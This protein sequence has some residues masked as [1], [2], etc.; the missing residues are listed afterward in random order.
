[1][2]LALTALLGGCMM[3]GVGWGGASSEC[4]N[5]GASAGSQ[6]SMPSCPGGTYQCGYGC[7]SLSALCCTSQ[8]DESTWD[9]GTSECPSMKLSSCNDNP[10]GSCKGTVSGTV[11]PMAASDFCCS[12][13]SDVG[14]LDCTDGTVVCNLMCV[15]VGA[16]CCSL[17]DSSDCGKVGGVMQSGGGGGGTCDGPTSTDGGDGETGTDAGDIETGTCD[18][19]SPTNACGACSCTGDGTCNANSSTCGGSVC[20]WAGPGSVVGNAPFCG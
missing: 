10:S 18:G 16:T 19:N 4:G 2:G 11:N 8:Q 5:G 13:N 6:R 9:Q 15:A 14:S 3:V 20:W 12:T 7:L 17:T 1:M